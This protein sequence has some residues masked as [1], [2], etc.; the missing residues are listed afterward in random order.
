MRW[1][2][3]VNNKKAINIPLRNF[4]KA[5]TTSKIVTRFIKTIFEDS[6]KVL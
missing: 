4:C 3:G 6:K 2:T 5:P 1:Y